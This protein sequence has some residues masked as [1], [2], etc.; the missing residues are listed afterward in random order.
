MTSWRGK[1]LVR[2][3]V[4]FV[5][6]LVVLVVAFATDSLWSAPIIAVTGD[7]LAIKSKWMM[8]RHGID[9]GRVPIRGNPTV[10]TACALHAQAEGKPFRVRYDIQGYDSAVAGAVVR[11]TAGRVYA[12]TFDGSPQGHGGVSLFAQ[13]V[14]TTACPEPVHL[15]VNPAR[16]INCFQ[17][18]LAYPKN[19]MSPNMEPY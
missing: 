8:G 2:V 5:A 9:C 19:I 10:A 16:R 3:L 12:L 14:S 15:W 1:R 6:C 17:K 18:E 7:A 13:R 4:L 11:T